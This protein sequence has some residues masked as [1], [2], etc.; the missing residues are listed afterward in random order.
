MRRVCTFEARGAK[1]GVWLLLMLNHAAA[2]VAAAAA[3]MGARE[4]RLQNPLPIMAQPTLLLMRGLGP[5]TQS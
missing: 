5:T 2:A 1:G 4:N 3:A